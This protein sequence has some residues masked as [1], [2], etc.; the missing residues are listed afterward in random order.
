MPML[1]TVPGQ[2]LK[3]MVTSGLKEDHAVEVLTNTYRHCL[4][5]HLQ[6]R[7]ETSNATVNWGQG[8]ENR[9]RKRH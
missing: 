2:L 3:Q 1:G 4:V 6:D 7:Q 8:L 9:L 5:E